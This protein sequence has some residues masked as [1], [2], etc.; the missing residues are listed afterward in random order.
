MTDKYFTYTRVLRAAL[1]YVRES[2]TW[3][4]G[5]AARSSA[6]GLGNYAAPNGALHAIM[7]PLAAELAP[8]RIKCVASGLTRTGF[9]RS[10]GTVF[11]PPLTCSDARTQSLSASAPPMISISSVVIAAWRARLYLSDSLAIMSFA[12]R[13]AES[14]AV[15]CAPKKPACVSSRAR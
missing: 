5:A 9:W 14:I 2:I 15:I 8:V 13:V 6:P 3:L 12:L 7:G 4:T 10:I 1:P 11:A